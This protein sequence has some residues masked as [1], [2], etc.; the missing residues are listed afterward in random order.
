[1]LVSAAAAIGT[2][3]GAPSCEIDG[4]QRIVAVGDV[5]G[6]HDRLAAILRKTGLLDDRLRWAGGRA[7]LVQLG[8]VVDRGADSRKALDLL[9][10]VEQEA[11]AAGG[12]VHALIGNHEVMRLLGDFRFVAPGEYEA[13][14]T[15]DSTRQRQV[16]L[17]KAAPEAREQLLKDTPLGFLE[18]LDAFSPR[19]DYGSWLRKHDTVV[20]INGIVFVHGGISP[21]VAAQSCDTIN[22]TVRRELTDDLEQTRTEPLAS[23]AAREDGPLWYRGLA[24]EPDTFGP[25]L[26]TILQQQGA[27]AIVVA[28]SVTSDG[29]IRARFGGRVVQID[30]GMQPAYVTGGRASALDIHDGTWTAVYED[31]TETMAA[32]PAGQAAAERSQP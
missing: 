7:H 14:L 29:R 21:P 11:A 25:A 16:L 8:D 4:V 1:M 12:Q 19:G 9:R 2:L 32:P 20:R 27:R 3:R 5:H 6:A 15:N 10:R 23:L 24:Q 22:A 18:M 26:D 28:H 17:D 30:T 13:F 31:R